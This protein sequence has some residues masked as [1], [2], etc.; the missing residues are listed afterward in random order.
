METRI[1]EFRKAKGYSLKHLSLKTGIKYNSLWKYENNGTRNIPNDVLETLATI[2]DTTSAELLGAKVN[3]K[4]NKAVKKALT[5]DEL[6]NE[7]NLT[8]REVGEL[9][10]LEALPKLFFEDG[11]ITEKDEEDLRAVLQ[12]IFITSIKRR[13]N[14]K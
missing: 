5:N 9:K 4:A 11:D 8:E 7:L 12:N 13:R 3:D 14:K 6:I 10:R 1:K 2:L